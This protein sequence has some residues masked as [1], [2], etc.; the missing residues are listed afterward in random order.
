M[1]DP[2]CYFVGRLTFSSFRRAHCLRWLIKKGKYGDLQVYWDELERYYDIGRIWMEKKRE[3][4]ADDGLCRNHHREIFTPE[5]NRE[6]ERRWYAD[7]PPVY[8]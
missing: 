1:S 7:D 4:E 5:W 8:V 6:W 2:S 3:D